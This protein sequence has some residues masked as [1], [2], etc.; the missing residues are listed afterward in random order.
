MHLEAAPGG[1]AFLGEPRIRVIGRRDGLLG[2]L[3]R[4]IA[5]MQ[6]S[7]AFLI[8]LRPHLPPSASRA[9][10]TPRAACRADA[11]PLPAP[12]T[13]AEIRRAR[14]DQ[15]PSHLTPTPADISNPAAC[16]PPRRL[17]GRSSLPHIAAGS[18]VPVAR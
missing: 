5:P 13:A 10:G 18:P 17:D 2:S 14:T 15:S 11:P 6:L 8:I 16:A 1:V 7:L 12:A 3:R 4:A 9:G